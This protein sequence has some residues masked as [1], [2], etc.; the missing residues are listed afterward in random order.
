MECLE[1]DAKLELQAK[2]KGINRI[3]VIKRKNYNTGAYIL[4]ILILRVLSVNKK[5]PMR[6]LTPPCQ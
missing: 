6:V 3:F 2:R 5:F 1:E 4:R